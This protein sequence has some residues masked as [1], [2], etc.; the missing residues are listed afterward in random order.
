MHLPV[1][2]A[3]FVY[4]D[5]ETW[6]EEMVVASCEPG[7]AMREVP[8]MVSEFICFTAILEMGSIRRYSAKEIIWQ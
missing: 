8:E 5:P 2:D 7:A 1:C 3:S 6:L 4:L